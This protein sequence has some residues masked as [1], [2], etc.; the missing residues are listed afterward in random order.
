MLLLFIY[1]AQVY[2]T[3]TILADSHSQSVSALPKA[4]P[5]VI[6]IAL[7]KTSYPYHFADD[8]NIADGLMVDL[9]QLWAQKQKVKIKF[10]ILPWT[11]TLAQVA[12]G[13]IDIHAGL[14]ILKSREEMFIFSHSIFPLYT[15]VYINRSLK[16]IESMADLRPYTIGMVSGS[17]HVLMLGAKH[18]ELKQRVYPSRHSLYESALNNEILV[19]TGLEKLSTLY[20]HYKE[21]NRLYPPYK[22][23]RYQQGKYGVAVAKTNPA[24]MQFIEEGFAKISG[25]EKAKIERKWLGLDKKSNSLSITFSPDFPP[26]SALSPTL[27]PQGLLIDMWRLWSKQTGQ[28]IEFNARESSKTLDLVRDQHA[29]VHLGYPENKLIGLR[30]AK[31]VYQPTANVYVNNRLKGLSTLEQ[32]KGETIGVLSQVSFREELEHKYSYLNIQYFSTLSSML[33]AAEVG[34]ISAM[35]SSIDFMNIKLVEASLQSSFYRLIEPVFTAKLS[36]YVNENNQ[37]L[38]EII[39]DGFEQIPLHEL[40]MLEE[41]WL[42]D[43]GSHYYRHLQQKINLSPEENDFIKKRA[44]K[45]D[46]IQ[47]GMINSLAPVEFI[48]QQGEFDGINKQVL[49]LISSRTGI[50]F[51]YNGFDSWQQ[52]YQ[53]LLDGKIDMLAGITPNEERKKNLLFSDSYWQMPWVVLHPQ[54][55]G[56]QTNLKD[57]YGKRLAIV[58]GYHLINKLRREHPLITLKLVSNVNEGILAV[59]QGQADGLIE[60]IAIATESLKQESLVPLMISVVENVKLDTI[61][62]AMR[63]ELTRLKSILNKGLLSISESE[64]QNIYEKWFTVA[65]KTGLDKAVVMRVAAQIGVIILIIIVVIILWNRRLYK[66]IKH[67]QALEEQMKHMAT[68]DELTGLANRVLLKDRINTAIGFHQRQ[69]LQMAVLFMDLDGFKTINDTYGHDVGDELL[70]QVAERLQTCVRKSDTVVRFGGDEFVLLLTGI[71]NS[72]EAA[73]IAEKVLK[74]MQTGFELSVGDIMIGC[75]IGVAMFPGDGDNDTELLKVADTLMYQVK[76]T[77]KNHYIFNS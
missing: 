52:V 40:A 16:K 20:P 22:R 30:I 5:N 49:D 26:F 43:N 47:V 2:A 10:V 28:N 7:N 54:Y 9:W 24:L 37:R 61:H 60:T 62:F 31:Q 21:L 57:F 74:L 14:S 13:N 6:T 41:R 17:A 4:I 15:N 48:N 70:V 36:A 3:K 39:A 12:S 51:Q 19:F 46:A 25:E 63:N 53:A 68:H 67:R 33:R 66:E 65:I 50:T 18:P 11:D 27:E 44:L 77:G 75:S 55:L 1:P 29:D 32:L 72:A 45:N 38:A 76:A 34:D 56:K 71:N 35:I 69:Q 59:Q 73:F 8:N 42:N 23:L 58:K 64:K